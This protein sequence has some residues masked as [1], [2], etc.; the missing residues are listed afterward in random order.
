M[1][2]LA[3]FAEPFCLGPASKLNT[4]GKL[5][6]GKCLLKFI[7]EEPA[8]SYIIKNNNFNSHVFCEVN[9]TKARALVE[10]CDGVLSVMDP[11]GIILAHQLNKPSI[12]IDSLLY[13]WTINGDIFHNNNSENNFK[14]NINL[15]YQLANYSLVQEFIGVKEKVNNLNSNK[16]KMV[17]PI[18]IKN[19]YDLNENSEI[20]KN[21]IL[22][23]CGGLINN[24]IPLQHSIKYLKLIIKLFSQYNYLIA[25]H[26]EIAK[27]FNKDNIRFLNTTNLLSTMKRSKC[28]FFP[29]GLTTFFEAVYQKIPCVFLPEFHYGHYYN[30]ALIKTQISIPEFHYPISRKYYHH[31]DISINLNA[32]IEFINNLNNE[33][34][35]LQE[36]IGQLIINSTIPKYN[37]IGKDYI[38]VLLEI[39]L[40]LNLI[41]ND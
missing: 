36:E 17:S 18:I 29:G 35:Y 20:D 31:E 4:I 5:L 39:L 16:I 19:Q 26:P 10:K 6:K 7:G 2:T 9:S 21:C 32:S 1:K 33:I 40:E 28:M 30:K 11:Y 24:I 13:Y 34:D 15:A 8:Y 3:C 22:I 27:V 12:F 38:S 14:D 37:V 25:V 23:N 41:N